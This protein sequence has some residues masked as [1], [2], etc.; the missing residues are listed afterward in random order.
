MAVEARFHFS[1]KRE[2]RYSTAYFLNPEI[3]AL[4]RD[5]LGEEIRVTQKKRLH[6]QLRYCYNQSLL[7]QRGSEEVGAKPEDIRKLD[8]LELLPILMTK[9]DEGENAFESPVN[10]DYSF[11]THICATTVA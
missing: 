7:Y 1:M 5:Q 6:P 4:S 10:Y 3:N 11:G 8:D 2:I 9:E